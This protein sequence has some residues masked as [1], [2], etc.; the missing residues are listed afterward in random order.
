[1]VTIKNNKGD[2]YL[3]FKPIFEEERQFF[4]EKT[5]IELPTDCWRNGTKIYLDITCNKPLYQ[6]KVI[7]SN[8]IINKNNVE[9]F[10]E[11]QQKKINEIISL[12][13]NKLKQLY[14]NSFNNLFEF[15]LE[16][17]DHKFVIGYSGGKDSVTLYKIWLDVINY[18]QNKYEISINYVVNFANTSNDTADTYKFIKSEI[19]RDK[20][21]PSA[22][23]L[24][25]NIP[26]NEHVNI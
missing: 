26:P 5:N 17:K 16:H 22:S 24:F 3:G 4:K 21:I 6:F 19:P 12:N 25:I 14:D 18:I 11:Y 8:I 9:L 1:L 7:N 20:I 10:T 2:N 15:V 13:T 23:N